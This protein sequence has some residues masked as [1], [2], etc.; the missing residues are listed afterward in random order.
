[1]KFLNRE[2]IKTLFKELSMQDYPNNDMLTAVIN[3]IDNTKADKDHN[4]DDLYY[5]KAYVDTYITKI[6]ALETKIGDGFEEI[7]SEEI[8][9]LFAN[10]K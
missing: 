5:S 6:S 1:M 10:N 7:T 4:H 8:Q 9:A 3:A 2:G